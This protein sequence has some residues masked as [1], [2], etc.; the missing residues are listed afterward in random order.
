M[1]RKSCLR[2]PGYLSLI[3]G[4]SLGHSFSVNVMI[5]IRIWGNCHGLWSSGKD[6][7]ILCVQALLFLLL[8]YPH[9]YIY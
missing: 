6:M 1:L 3:W 9:P 4:K 7:Y 8:F 2:V 5:E